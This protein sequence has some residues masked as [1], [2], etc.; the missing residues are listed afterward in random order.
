[1]KLS[2]ITFSR[3]PRLLA[4]EVLQNVR[5]LE[6]SKSMIT[7]SSELGNTT[8]T[9]LEVKTSS[10][11]PYFQQLPKQLADFFKKYPPPPFRTYSGKPTTIDAED[12][13]PFLT[14]KNP[15]TNKWN[16]PK[17]SLRHQSVLYKMAYRLGISHLMPKLLNDKK[18]YE[19]KHLTKTPV[20][21]SVQFK[22]SKGER[23]KEQRIKEVQEA[24]A[25]A[26]ETIADAR[27][28]AYRRKLNRKNVKVPR[29]F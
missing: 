1:M 24:L 19:E 23:T 12:A 6:A 3:M 11:N 14:N 18:F 20:R 9:A 26:D 2:P 29:W 15:I 21:G 16:S 22:L 5:R 25:K 8:T 4:S 28:A 13:N 7:R 17:Y 27:G 10:L